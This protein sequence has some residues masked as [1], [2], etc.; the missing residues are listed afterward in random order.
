VPTTA[1]NFAVW[2]GEYDW[3]RAGE[4][5]S[6][7]WG[8][9]E[10]QWHGTLLPRIHRFLPSET[11]LEIAPGYG[12]WSQYLREHCDRLVLVDLSEQ[13]IDACRERFAG[14]SGVTCFVND[15]L[16]LAMVEDE[17]VDFAFSFDSLVHVEE[18]V[19]AAYL[20]ELSG[21][22][23]PDG[24][25]FV[26]HSN[27]GRYG[28]YFGAI[29]SI[30]P[31]RLRQLLV[32]SHVVEHDEWRALSMTAERFDA[33]CRAAGLQCI[34]QELVNWNTRRLIDCLSTFAKADSKWSR[35]PLV[36]ENGE[37]MAEARQVKRRAALYPS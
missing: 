5:W 3:S 25:G 29:R 9:S 36:V 35:T 31:T 20:R 10:A 19:V 24:A 18:D 28:R 17:S 12:R 16:S 21:K 4:E 33:A 32:D 37:F 14:D 2:G 11:I 13:C 30:W 34:T 22:L 1:E 8:S 6:E 7:A 26:H 15:G 27:A 23:K